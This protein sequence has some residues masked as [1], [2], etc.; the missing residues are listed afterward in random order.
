MTQGRSSASTGI[1]SFSTT[2]TDFLRRNYVPRETRH[3]HLLLCVLLWSVLSFFFTSR[4]VIATVEV[5]GESMEPTLVDSE[6]RLVHRWSLLVREPRRGELVVLKDHIDESWCIK[7]VVAMPGDVVEFRAG[8]VHVNGAPLDEPYLAFNTVTEP[9]R[10]AGA[11][12][13]VGEG[14]FFVLGDN[15]ANSVDSRT[16]GPLRRASLLGV[17][18]E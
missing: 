17:V 1:A 7:R 2:A 15:R 12:V 8:R 9:Q 6:R 3:T 11:R 14:R 18:N 5:D 4:Y 16:Y 10:P 13:T